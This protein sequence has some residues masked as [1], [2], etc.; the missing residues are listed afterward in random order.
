MTSHF[1]GGVPAFVAR[2]P[3]RLES[4]SQVSGGPVQV[5]LTV[6]EYPPSRE[7]DPTWLPTSWATKPGV[8]WAG[9]RTC[10]ELYVLRLIEYGGW[11]GVWV[12]AYGHPRFRPEFRRV[13]FTEGDGFPSL[14]EAGAPD[15]V[16][17]RFKSVMNRNGRAGGCWDLVAWRSDG[18]VGFLE[19][20]LKDSALSSQRRWLESARAEGFSADDFLLVKCRPLALSE[21]DDEEPQGGLD[22]P[23]PCP[24]C[25]G[26]PFGPPDGLGRICSLCGW[27]WMANVPSGGDGSY[28]TE[29]RDGLR[30]D[31]RMEPIGP[32]QPVQ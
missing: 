10:A 4:M 12:N 13:W 20:K 30:R 3:G 19:V 5:G 14:E 22:P 31:S 18:G 2:G 17:D 1:L 32:L 23:N 7:I 15:G 8:D 26:V 9:H 16:A 27:G 24:K 11:N 29:A 21:P 6:V 25:G 28:Q